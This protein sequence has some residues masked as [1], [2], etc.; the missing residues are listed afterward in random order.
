V[1]ASGTVLIAAGLYAWDQLRF[2]AN[3]APIAGTPVVLRIQPS[4]DARSRA[5]VREGIVLMHR[6][7]DRQA[8]GPPRRPVEARLA[9]SNARA[10]FA[11]LRGAGS[12]GLA[13]PGWLCINTAR[14][15]WPT[16]VAGRR[17]PRR[18]PRRT[19]RLSSPSGQGSATSAR[20]PK[21]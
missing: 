15:S 4:V 19:R 5:L 14:D 3:S 6:Y 2:P 9:S 17:P 8:G 20:Y 21:L 11:S 1:Y 7:L 10:P 12:I 16:T 13:T 18:A